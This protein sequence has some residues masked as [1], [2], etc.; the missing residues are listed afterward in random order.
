MP[1]NSLP[2]SAPGV[3]TKAF[4]SV[5]WGKFSFAFREKV[6]QI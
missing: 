5:F 6:Y 4:V 3:E 1:Q 2:V